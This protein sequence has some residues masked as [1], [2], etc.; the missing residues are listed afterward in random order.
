[1]LTPSDQGELS[2][3]FKL[4]DPLCDGVITPEQLVRL[5]TLIAADPAACR[6]CFSYLEMH[7]AL[8]LLFRE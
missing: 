8:H 1:M 6:F 5:K 3:L 4:A 7:L 2:E